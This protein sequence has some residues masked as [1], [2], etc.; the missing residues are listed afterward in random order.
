VVC[1][2]QNLL[3]EYSADV[4]RCQQGILHMDISR[5][6]IKEKLRLCRSGMDVIEKV[7]GFTNPSLSA[8]LRV[9]LGQYKAHLHS[10]MN[11]LDEELDKLGEGIAKLEFELSGIDARKGSMDQLLRVLNEF[12]M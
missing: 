11:D 12:P 4:S 6:E 7:L 2:I 8:D 9:A 5:G 1:Q 3:D 10:R